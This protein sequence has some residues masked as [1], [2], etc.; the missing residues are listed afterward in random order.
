[1][2]VNDIR[3]MLKKYI[4][5]N[6]LT[7]SQYLSLKLYNLYNASYN[8]SEYKM[9]CDIILT[10][11]LTEHE[12]LLNEFTKHNIKF[13]VNNIDIFTDFCIPKQYMP[14]SYNDATAYLLSIHLR[15]IDT[16][17]HAD[18]DLGY[19]LNLFVLDILNIDNNYEKVLIVDDSS[20]NDYAEMRSNKHIS[21]VNRIDI[22]QKE[23]N[24]SKY[25]EY[26]NLKLDNNKDYD[27][28]TDLIFDYITKSYKLHIIYLLKDIN[29]AYIKIL[30]NK[31]TEK[32]Y[33]YRYVKNN[34]IGKR[35]K[36]C[37][38]IKNI[39]YKEIIECLMYAQHMIKG[40][41]E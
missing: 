35:L 9:L 39:N 24:N 15:F 27:N 38:T 17:Y 34:F 5:D 31:N 1:M 12:D 25:A 6:F 30:S 22:T 2:K 10:N 18:L 20:L 29:N 32:Y 14:S 21:A 26:Y 3:D 16:T 7:E 8:S 23:M 37:K 11:F 36:K 41:I 28:L 4:E 40:E 13:Q 19:V 33:L